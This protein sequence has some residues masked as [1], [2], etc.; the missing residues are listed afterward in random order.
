MWTDDKIEKLTKMWEGG[1][2]AGKIAD[3][4][5]DGTSRN[6]VLGKA[7]RLGL[8]GRCTPISTLEA[9]FERVCDRVIEGVNGE[10]PTIN[11]A[12]IAEGM[13]ISKAQQ[14]WDERIEATHG[15]DPA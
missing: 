5:G 12:A 4:L 13:N 8:S 11:R 10:H 2:S 7:S 9:R 15:G 3:A 1:A 14:M 6:A